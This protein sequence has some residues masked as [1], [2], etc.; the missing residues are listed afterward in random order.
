M[1]FYFCRV[2]SYD[3]ENQLVAMGAITHTRPHT[4][5]AAVVNIRKF[6]SFDGTL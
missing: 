4:I 2:L 3:Q 1:H 6:V 5:E